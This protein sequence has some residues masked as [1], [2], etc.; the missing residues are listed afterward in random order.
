MYRLSQS[1]HAD[2]FVLKGAMLFVL[3]LEDLHRPT[4][5]LDLLCLGDLS[6]PSLRSIFEDV[7]EIPF[8][9]SVAAIGF[10]AL[11]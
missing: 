7:C 5:D 11:M 10:P 4:H 9:P 6:S 1:P 3:W 8:D 2:R